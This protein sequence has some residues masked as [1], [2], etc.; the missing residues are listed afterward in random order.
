MKK[1]LSLMQDRGLVVNA[2]EG[3]SEVSEPVSVYLGFD[4]TGPSLHVGH[5]AGILVLKRLSLLGH[6]PLALI[7]GATGM[8]GDPSGK[9]AERVLLDKNTVEENANALKKLLQK[10]IP[11][12]EIVNNF[13]WLGEITLVDFL[14]DVAKHFRLGNM[15]AKESVKQRLGSDEG[16]SFTEFSYQLLQAYDFYHLFKDRGVSLQ[17]GGS[18]QWGNITAGIDFIRK[19]LSKKVH[20]LTYPLL[21][22]SK[23]NKL[24]KTEKGAVW[25]DAAK[26]SPYELYQ[27]VY[28]LDDC[29]MP[30]VASLLTLLENEEV[31]ELLMQL[32]E[33]P[34]EV[35][36]ALSRE[37]VRL[38]HGEEGVLSA[39]N[40]TQAM[41]PGKVSEL[42]EEALAVL[43]AT[44]FGVNLASH[45]ILGKKWSDVL[46]L[47]GISAS[48]SEIKRLVDQGGIYINSRVLTSSEEVVSSEDVIFSKYIVVSRGRKKKLVLIIG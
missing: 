15:L 48:K 36:A 6:K 28:G 7:G 25:L 16:M 22:D 10:F 19:V 45:N 2:S 33:K 14:R 40:I 20:G 34:E 27:Y 24:G 13:S 39:Q 5:L 29:E 47:S 21:T 26:T 41:L 30:R 43:I 1:F 17:V 35:K 23:G 3:L 9:S 46:V 42:S 4:P 18:D 8:I 31:K 44:G 37:V 38:V 32:K 12:I 11:E